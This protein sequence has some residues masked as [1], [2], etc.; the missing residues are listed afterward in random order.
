VGLVEAHHTERVRVDWADT[1]SGG[2]MHFIAAFRYAERAEAGLRRN[3]GLLD[4][5]GD[6]PRRSVEAEFHAQPRFDDE[7][8]V[9]I[10][11]D[12]L[13]QTS[14]TWTWEISRAEELCA[15]GRYSVVHVDAA[16]KPERIP[17]EVRA[18]LEGLL[19]S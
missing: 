9:R 7:L 5:W 10:G 1:D 17:L 11:L 15:E 2:F 14:I 6:Y 19:G 4:D 3:L 8:E 13:G 18:T 12:R 16:D